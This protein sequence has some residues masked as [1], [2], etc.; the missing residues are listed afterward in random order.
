MS[1]AHISKIIFLNL[2]EK[3]EWWWGGIVVVV[4]AAAGHSSSE[5]PLKRSLLTPVYK[6]LKK[7]HCFEL[8][9]SSREYNQCKENKHCRCKV[10]LNISIC[11][12]RKHLFSA[13]PYSWPQ[14]I[15]HWMILLNRKHY[16][17][18]NDDIINPITGDDGEMII[19]MTACSCRMAEQLNN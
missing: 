13:L 5:S 18:D 3:S 2:R 11:V 10:A 17:D 19:P 6:R 7:V 9:I 16:L 14:V 8:L 4:G 15:S 1:T 12:N